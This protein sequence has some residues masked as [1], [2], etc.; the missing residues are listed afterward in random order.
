LLF[1]AVKLRDAREFEFAINEIDSAI[2]NIMATIRYLM[3]LK[4][5]E[6]EELFGGRL[7]S[8]DTPEHLRTALYRVI[9]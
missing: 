5:E 4:N 1:W 3:D 6:R 2:K 7:I 9:N 8:G